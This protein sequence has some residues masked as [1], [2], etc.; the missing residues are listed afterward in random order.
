MHVHV[1]L[2]CDPMD[3]SLPGSSVYGIS[4]ARL[5]ESFSLSGKFVISSVLSRCSKNLKWRT[6]QCYSSML[7]LSF[8]CKQR[9]IHP[10][11]V[12]VGQPKDMKRREAQ[13]SILA[14][15]FIWFFLL[16]LSE[17]YVNWASQESCLTRGPHSSPGPS[18]VL[19]LQAFPFLSFSHCQF[20][21]PFPIL[22]T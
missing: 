22:T 12:R 18:F 2:F 5:L 14:P 10:W 3:C 21:L 13:S 4:Q 11:G 20:G 7:Q 9:K 19:C 8:I 16:P 1:Q 6:C 17:P 15:L